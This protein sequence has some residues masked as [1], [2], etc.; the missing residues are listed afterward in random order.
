MEGQSSSTLFQR[1]TDVT[2][3]RAQTPL[4]FLLQW[5]SYLSYCWVS[6]QTR[7]YERLFASKP[8][9]TLHS[10]V[11]PP[12]EFWVRS[13]PTLFLTRTGPERGSR[14][15]W[16]AALPP[17]LWPMGPLNI[18]RVYNVFYV[19]LVISFSLVVIWYWLTVARWKSKKR[20]DE[21]VI[22]LEKKY[23]K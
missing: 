5:T 13:V 2:V 4:N 3:T 17:K 1:R 21:C 14:G 7:S 8:L 22:F 12:L 15:G 16:V 6:T 19:F 20:I 10:I 23:I 9:F 18:Y 11:R